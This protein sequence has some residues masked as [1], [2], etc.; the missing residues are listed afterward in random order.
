MAERRAWLGAIALIALLVVLAQL[1]GPVAPTALDR[2]LSTVRSTPDGA[3]AL[4]LALP[5]LGIPVARRITPLVDAD[6]IAGPLAVLAPQPAPSPRE[7]HALKQ[8]VAHGGLLIYVPAAWG[9]PG[10]DTLGLPA[11][12]RIQ[13]RAPGRPAPK[14][15]RAQIAAE[16][17]GPR[18]DWVF[19]RIRDS[20]QVAARN[21]AEASDS[22][23][24]ATPDTGATA[25]QDSSAAA[26]KDSSRT[27]ARAS[28]GAAG[29]AAGKAATRDSA[30]DEDEEPADTAEVMASDSEQVVTGDTTFLPAVA[31]GRPLARRT[32][33]TARRVAGRYYA[34]GRPVV[35]VSDSF[36]LALE[37]R[38]GQGRV[39]ALSDA[40]MLAN[41]GVRAH[42]VAAVV[43]DFAAQ[44]VAPG[45]PLV[46][47]EYHHGLRGG[48]IMAGLGKLVRRYGLEGTL[49]QL[50]VVLLLVMLVAARR[51]GAPLPA[52]VR[53]RRSPLEHVDALASAYAAARARRL[54]RLLLLGG[55]ARRLGRPRPR[56]LAEA[57]GML[58]RV[59]SA[60]PAA[61]PHTRSLAR[62]LRNPDAGLATI[63]RGVDSVLKEIKR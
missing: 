12:Y 10:L 45:R 36:P 48:S 54:P 35:V 31:K 46:F 28:A 44:A 50:A 5:A 49:L 41:E 63:A 32:S 14:G 37:A 52:A 6:T 59:A 7:L 51:L 43:A 42:R 38:I 17:R 26:P 40:D 62:T 33:G 47:D 57:D 23:D 21:S 29:H 11:I 19:V 34:P 53:A 58:E 18:Y 55:L 9:D 15:A 24:A 1:G 8:W 39:L 22:V 16:L 56:T 61:T 3:R 60:R 27:A 30:D 13:V 20:A 25:L 2:R 4:Y